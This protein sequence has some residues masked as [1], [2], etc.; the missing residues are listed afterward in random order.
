MNEDLSIKKRKESHFIYLK[1]LCLHNFRF[2]YQDYI[3]VPA[4]SYIT[5]DEERG[6]NHVVEIIK[7]LD[8]KYLDCLIK[9]KNVKQSSLGF[10]KRKEIKKYIEIKEDLK[11]KLMGKNVVVIDDVL[12]TRS[13]ISRC[14]YLIKQCKVKKIS[15]LVISYTSR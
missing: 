6:F 15:F 1:S 9:T 3:F 13:T 11:D 14:M 8:V 7:S 12:T 2:L 4:P 5:A 10:N